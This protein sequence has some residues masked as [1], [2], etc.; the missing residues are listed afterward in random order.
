VRD[1]LTATIRALRN[2]FI[3]KSSL[4]ATLQF[5]RMGKRAT[6]RVLTETADMD[7]VAFAA[8]RQ[9]SFLSKTQVEAFF[10][11]IPREAT[12]DQLLFELIYRHGLRRREAVL[13]RKDWIRDR[14]WIHRVKHGASGEYPIHPRSRRLLWAWL[15]ERGEDKNPHL[16]TTR[17]SAARPMSASMVY[18]LFRRYATFAGIPLEL[19][20]PHVLRHSIATHLLEAGRDIVDV[21]DWLGH[22][23]ISSTQV[24]AR[25][26]NKRRDATYAECLRSEAIAANNGS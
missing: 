17:Q 4:V 14:I 24:Y 5:M 8:R 10:A 15:A 9:L 18:A 22:T 19:Q 20:H 12:R 13:I 2:S 3:E 21:Q 6:L 7:V 1:R 26:T 11:V 16:F 23:E 25:V